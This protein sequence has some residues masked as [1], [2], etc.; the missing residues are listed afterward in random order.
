MDIAGAASACFPRQ[1]YNFEYSNGLFA[2][3]ATA[4]FSRHEIQLR[5]QL[6]FVFLAMNSNCEYSYGLFSL[7]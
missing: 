6:R 3:T 1:E 2:S 4:C 7:P 5:V